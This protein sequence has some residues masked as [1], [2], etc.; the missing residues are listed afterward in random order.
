MV[1]AMACGTPVVAFNRG[2]ASEV[3]KHGETG[4]VVNTLDEM[5][6]AVEE[7]HRIDPRSCREHTRQKFDV[8]RMVGEYLAA[9]E[10]ILAASQQQHVS[11]EL[12]G[13]AVLMER[14]SRL[15]PSPGT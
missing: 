12:D 5:A 14:T 8:F 1:E 13:P 7:V 4:F 2:A 11:E 15:A 9:Y 10:R 3:V 6:S